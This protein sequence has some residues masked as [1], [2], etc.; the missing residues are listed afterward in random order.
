MIRAVGQICAPGA[1]KTLAT[2]Y[3]AD[4]VSCA[5]GVW[6]ESNPPKRMLTFRVDDTMY[7]MLVPVPL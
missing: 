6:Y 7:A 2:A 4:D 5:T 1:P 3:Q